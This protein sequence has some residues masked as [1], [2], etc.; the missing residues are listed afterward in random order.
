MR[1]LE[2]LRT[3]FINA[4]FPLIHLTHAIPPVLITPAIR[5]VGATIDARNLWQ[6]RLKDLL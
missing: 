1:V 2:F 3:T 5:S 4:A 6:K